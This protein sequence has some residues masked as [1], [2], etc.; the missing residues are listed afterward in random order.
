[1]TG[2]SG[3][4]GV[5]EVRREFRSVV[6]QFASGVAVVVAM[7]G[8]E[9][10]A[11][12][13]SSFV[14]VSSDPPLVA[15]FFA[16]G[17]RTHGF[18]VENGRF[19]VSVLRREDHGLARRFARTSRPTGWAG[20]AGVPLVLRE[21]EPPILAQALAWLDCRVVQ[22]VPM[23]DHGCFVAEVLALGRDPEAEPLVYYRGR[24]HALGRPAAPAP[25]ATFE[26]SDLTAD[27]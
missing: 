4:E 25:W 1:M 16:N 17:T 21:P 15:V 18:L 12:T 19:S 24:F 3:V 8:D 11:A 14:A 27:W 22:V 13:A 10:H 5:A 2:Q 7:A 6:G 23:G 26:R 20:L 9:P